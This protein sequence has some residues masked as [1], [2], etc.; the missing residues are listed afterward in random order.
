M[1]RGRDCLCAS[2]VRQWHS[3]SQ[4]PLSSGSRCLSV[5]RSGTFQ[6]DV[7]RLATSEVPCGDADARGPHGRADQNAEGSVPHF[8]ASL[9]IGEPDGG[10]EHWPVCGP[11]RFNG[12]WNAS[13]ERPM[14]IISNTVSGSCSSPPSCGQ[15]H[16]ITPIKSGLHINALMGESSRLV[17][18]RT[19]ALRVF[20]PH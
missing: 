20:S 3:P 19:W 5:P 8:G 7:S 12:P 17:I 9:S 11:E 13:L 4:H 15:S 18:Q 14:L 1:I 16:V 10:C 2:T 6:R